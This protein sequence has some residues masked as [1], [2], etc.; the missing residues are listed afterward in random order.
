MI[1]NKMHLN[2]K[3][4]R[5]LRIKQELAPKKISPLNQLYSTLRSIYTACFNVPTLK[6]INILISP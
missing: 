4:K 1:S 2:V 5:K 6:Y 3:E